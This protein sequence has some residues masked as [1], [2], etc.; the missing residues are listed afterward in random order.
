VAERTNPL[1]PEHRRPLYS[2]RPPNDSTGKLILQCES[3]FAKHG[4]D[5]S[6]D[7]LIKLVVFR[8]WLLRY[9]E[10]PAFIPRRR[11]SLIPQA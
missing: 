7:L 3:K 4:I 1:S 2:L 5:L 10:A 8:K 9:E 6:V 11:H